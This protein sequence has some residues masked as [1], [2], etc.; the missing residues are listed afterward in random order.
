[1]KGGKKKD[2]YHLEW[3]WIRKLQR[4]GGHR[5]VTQSLQKSKPAGRPL[6]QPPGFYPSTE[7]HPPPSRTPSQLTGMSQTFQETF[8]P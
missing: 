2:A 1:M 4:T 7:P 8:L 6:V 3:S 5:E